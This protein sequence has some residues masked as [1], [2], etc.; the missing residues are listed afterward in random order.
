MNKKTCKVLCLIIFL[1]VVFGFA[2]CNKSVPTTSVQFCV[3]DLEG[4]PIKDA[5][6]T[7]KEEGKTDTTD[8]EGN[9][10]QLVVRVVHNDINKN[11]DWFG[12]TVTV[13]AEGFVPMVIFNCILYES[14]MR[15]VNL[16]L[17]NDDGTLPYTAYVEIPA[18]EIIRKLLD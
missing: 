10:T 16:R 14:K 12:V 6:V 5:V 1:S 3:T 17:F 4:N 11:E 13:K 9:T 7:I 2:A 18:V 15:Q 8:S